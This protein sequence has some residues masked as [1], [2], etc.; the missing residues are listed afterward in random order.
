MKNVLNSSISVGEYM[1]CGLPLHNIIS[2]LSDCSIRDVFY[3]RMNGGSVFVH[4]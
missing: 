3:N 4:W 2:I 1:I